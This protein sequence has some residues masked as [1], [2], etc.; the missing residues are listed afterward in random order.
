MQDGLSSILRK[1]SKI[2]LNVFSKVLYFLYTLIS[3]CSALV[4]YNE[5][6]NISLTKHL[7]ESKKLP[8]T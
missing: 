3:I 2:L 4:V 7:T 1:C 8:D 5:S 6:I